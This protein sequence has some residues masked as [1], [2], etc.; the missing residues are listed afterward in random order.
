M[1]QKLLLRL[2]RLSEDGLA[3][4]V[5]YLLAENRVLRSKLPARGPFEDSERA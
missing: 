5:E 2:A 4:Q 3:R 1:P